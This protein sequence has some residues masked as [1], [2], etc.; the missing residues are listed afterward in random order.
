MGKNIAVI[1]AGIA[2]LTCAYELQK[3]GHTVEV[4]EREAYVGGRM[5]TRTKDDLPFDIGANHLINL[6]TEMRAYAEEFD[7][8]W[9]RFNFVNYRLNL[10]G[11]IIPL[12]DGVSPKDKL[13]LAKAYIKY[14]NFP[15][16]YL[17]SNTLVE[18]DTDNAYDVAVEEMGQTFADNIVDTYVGVYQFHRAHE[19]S[20][21]GLLSQLNSTKT[22][23]KDWY[24]HQTK[25]GMI[26][27]PQA[28]ADRL[29][30]HLETPVQSVQ[31]L[32]DSVRVTTKDDAKE[33][34]LV[35]MATTATVAQGMYE[36]PTKP[37]ADVLAVPKYAE[38]ILVAYKAPQD[39]F[40]SPTGDTS[41]TVSAVWIPY[42]ESK[43]LSSYS[44]ESEKGDALMKNGKTLL[45]AFMREDGARE[46]LDKH[47]EDI[48]EATKQELIRICPKIDESTELENHDIYCWD[49]AMPKFFQGS[50]TKIKS[51]L[52][53]HQGDQNVWFA[54]DWLNSPWTEGAL[55]CGQRVAKEINKKYE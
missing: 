44:N 24:L 41:Q 53:T 50:L 4:F 18:Y 10:D 21:A 43:M 25:G 5:S 15:T 34:D 19:I 37:Q 20:R 33:Y 6:Y 51:F 55:R 13:K 22:Y 42:S 1:G 28:F 16:T 9:E 29:N 40:G 26:A 52:D 35:V 7:I 38:S 23:T 49:E 46:Y 54:G 39:L 30:V 36:N 14:K 8:E 47:D 45:I 2:G 12:F 3:A 31:A 17:D 48:Y 11:R 32:G 27:L